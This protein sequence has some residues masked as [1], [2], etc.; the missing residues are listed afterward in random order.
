MTVLTA[1]L[2]FSDLWRLLYAARRRAL[3]EEE[4]T[5]VKGLLGILK[6]GIP[7]SDGYNQRAEAFSLEM[8]SSGLFENW[9]DPQRLDE[10]MVEEPVVI[11]VGRDV[12]PFI[13][14][15]FQ[16]E[17]LGKPQGRER[18]APNLQRSRSALFSKN[19]LPVV[20]AQT[21]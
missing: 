11:S 19:K 18:L 17:E 8:L 3:S 15:G 6:E 12:R 13:R 7:G 14:V 4:L 20:V 21:G 10:L 1:R 9:R 16:I 2:I 5:A